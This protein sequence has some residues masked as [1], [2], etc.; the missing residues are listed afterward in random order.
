[1]GLFYCRNGR[2]IKNRAS[3]Q[4]RRGW[5]PYYWPEPSI[6]R[7]PCSGHPQSPEEIRQRADTGVRT[8]NCITLSSKC[9]SCTE[10]R[11]SLNQAT[12]SVM[13]GE[14]MATV[15]HPERKPDNKV[16]ASEINE[17]KIITRLGTMNTPSP[18][19]LSDIHDRHE[20]VFFQHVAVQSVFRRRGKIRGLEQHLGHFYPYTICVGCWGPCNPGASVAWVTDGRSMKVR[21]WSR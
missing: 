10:L 6:S 5:A 3:G 4:G 11:W 12:Q 17:N 21:R 14:S 8:N 15:A 2:A 7:A 13:S 1:M 19:E 9:H 16:L 20:P 18:D